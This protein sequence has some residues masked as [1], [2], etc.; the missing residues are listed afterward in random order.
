MAPESLMGKAIDSAPS[1]D[2]WAIGIMFYSMLFGNL[3]FFADDEDTIIKLIKTAPIKFPKDVPVTPETRELILKM[4]DRDVDKRFQL[5]DLLERDYYK[6]DDE[7]FREIVN[8]YHEELKNA[9]EEQ[10]NDS[11]L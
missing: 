4:L 5:M 9:K 6:Y 8:N 11:N 10:K 2:V 7:A 1:I 3:P